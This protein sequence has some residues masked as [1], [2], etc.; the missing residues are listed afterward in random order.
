MDA[1]STMLI[2]DDIDVNREMMATFFSDEYRIL[3]AG[4]GKETIYMIQ[5]YAKEISVILLGIIMPVMDG[6]EVLK[7]V[8]DSVYSIIPIIAV[9]A[10]ESYQLEALE[11]GAA[12]FISK[13]ADERVIKARIQN[14]LG[15][16]ALEKEQRLNKVLQKAKVETDDLINNIPGGIAIYR[17]TDHLE[18]LYFS[19]GELI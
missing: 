17:W 1:K 16:F 7:W 3:Y 13:P 12:D 15:R 18:T 10:D 4:N 19:D 14:V 5:K 8:K 6:I 11:N 9:T 2:V